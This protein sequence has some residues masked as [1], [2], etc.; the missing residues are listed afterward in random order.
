MAATAT[1]VVLDTETYALD[2]LAGALC[3]PFPVWALTGDV[4][5][6]VEVGRSRA[7]SRHG[8]C[9]AVSG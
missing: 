2:D 4:E 1:Q 7:H 9:R 5:R 8:T 6:R 3:Q